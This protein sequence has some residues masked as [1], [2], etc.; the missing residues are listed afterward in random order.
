[1]NSYIIY[2]KEIRE[3]VR[4]PR[5]LIIS[6][7]FIFFAIVSPLTAKFMPLIIKQMGEQVA[8]L[9]IPEPTY[10]DAYMQLFKNMN[11]IV[12]IVL[13]F[14]LC[15][16]IAS[17]KNKGIIPLIVTKGL[18]RSSIIIGKFLAHS[19]IYTIIYLVSCSI[20]YIYS[21]ILFPQHDIKTALLSLTIFGIYG[22]FLIS[23]IILASTVANS[24]GIAA[25]YGFGVYILSSIAASI[26][27]VKHFSPA[28]STTLSMQ[29]VESNV[30]ITE[31]IIS[32]I[33]STLVL[34][35]VFMVLSIMSFRKQEL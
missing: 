15:G 16:T 18:S 12:F 14:M 30:I 29:L 10:I 31:D 21:I 32:F 26:P 20:F 19:S 11:S 1:M 34:T 3:A 27:Y 6:S 8:F 22:I 25:L 33:L 2:K 35:I 7:L 24:Y 23:G 13:I 9:T 4:T 5:L 28:Y 17:E